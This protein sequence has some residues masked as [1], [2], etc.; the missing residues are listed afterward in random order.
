MN[1][2]KG[3][4]LFSLIK[5]IRIISSV[6]A[7]FTNE[8]TSNTNQCSIQE[9]KDI[10]FSF[11]D[12]TFRNVNRNSLGNNLTSFYMLPSTSPGTPTPGKQET[13]LR[14]DLPPTGK[15]H[16]DRRGDSHRA[17]LA[18]ETPKVRQGEVRLQPPQHSWRTRCLLGCFPYV[19]AALSR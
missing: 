1:I 4:R 14:T 2:S 8:L 18:Q 12:G 19:L 15:D 5:S 16:R 3:V 10:L 13:T 9:P 6:G 11:Y 7:K 17:A